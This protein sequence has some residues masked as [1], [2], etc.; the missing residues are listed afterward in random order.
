MLHKTK[1]YAYITNQ[2]RLLVFRH[3]QFPEAGIQVPGGTVEADEDLTAAVLREA[4]EETGLDN[5]QL[6]RYLGTA[7]YAPPDRPELHHRHYYHL[8]CATPPPETWLHGEMNASDGSPFIE[9]AF[10]WVQFPEGVPPLAGQQG[11]LLNQLGVS[12]K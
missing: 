4:R 12:I 10:Y 1:V 6:V 11:Q 9:F 5:L 2:N 3:T 7:V 8:C